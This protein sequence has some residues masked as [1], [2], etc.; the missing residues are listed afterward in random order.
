MWESKLQET[1]I[2][3]DN[4]IERRLQFDRG[5]RRITRTRVFNNDVTQSTILNYRFS[6]STRSTTTSNNNSRCL[7]ISRTRIS[8]CD[9]FKDRCGVKLCVDWECNLWTQSVVMRIII[10]KVIVLKSLDL[11]N[12]ITFSEDR[13]TSTKRR[14]NN[15]NVCTRTCCTN[16]K[17][18][19]N[20]LNIN[21]SSCISS[22]R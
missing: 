9:T 21:R 1:Q 10:T 2:K 17:N 14:D 19:I 22:T 11:T 4:I 3:V 6:D 15:L 18:A 8:Y 7:S 20:C 12:A 16:A 5:F 13:S